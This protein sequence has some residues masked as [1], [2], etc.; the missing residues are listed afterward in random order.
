MQ[1]IKNNYFKEQNSKTS[2]GN[3]FTYRKFVSPPA[4]RWLSFPLPLAPAPQSPTTLLSDPRPPTK[5]KTKIK[6][7]IERAPGPPYAGQP[8]LLNL[9][10]PNFCLP[11]PFRIHDPPQLS[12]SI[13][14]PSV[15]LRQVW[16]SSVGGAGCQCK[17]VGLR[18]QACRFPTN[19]FFHKI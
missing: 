18:L 13:P 15:L 14:V 9:Q 19:T 8:V 11:F 10:S 17:T 2:S 16:Q 3:F 6:T 1:N 12:S 7:K 4:E 5:T